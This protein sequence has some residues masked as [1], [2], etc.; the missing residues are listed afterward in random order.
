M[1]RE[2]SDWEIA[3]EFRHRWRHKYQGKPH[4]MNATDGFA[5]GARHGA[6]QAGLIHEDGPVGRERANNEVSEQVQTLLFQAKSILFEPRAFGGQG[7]T[8]PVKRPK[9]GTINDRG[10]PAAIVIGL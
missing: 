7:L 10:P 3:D 4:A 8:A 1:R 2:V 9:R 6:V 5:G